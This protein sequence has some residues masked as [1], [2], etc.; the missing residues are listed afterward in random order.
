MGVSSWLGERR[1]NALVMNV[2]HVLLRY[3]R[4]GECTR[5]P[6]EEGEPS[7][8]QISP[9]VASRLG[10]GR[11]SSRL[12]RPTR[13]FELLGHLHQIRERSCLHLLHDLASMGLNRD[14]ADTEF[15]SNLLIQ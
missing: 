3:S 2:A 10:T 14:F 8:E 11:Q 12:N 5:I 4:G 1:D 9:S 13:R 15:A 6:A 7:P